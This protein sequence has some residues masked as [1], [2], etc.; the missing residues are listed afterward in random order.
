MSH[1]MKGRFSAPLRSRT[2]LS[3]S[4][5]LL[6]L[7]R[8][9][10]FPEARPGQFVSIRVSDGPSP[11]LRRPYSIMDLTPRSL[12]LLVKVVGRGSAMLADTRPGRTIDLIGPLGGSAFPEPAGAG[13]VLVA[14]GTGLAPLVFASR[15]WRRAR[16]G[17]ETHLLYGAS[18][19]GELLGALAERDFDERSFSTLDGTAGFRGDVVQLCERLLDEGRL[20]GRLLYSCGPRGMVRALAERA[21]GRFV[22]HYTSLECVMAC[23]LGA[24][25]GCTVPVT[26]P[27]GSAFKTVC[28]DGTVF[29][30]AEIAWEEWEG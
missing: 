4:C 10:G 14:G 16:L 22:E 23:G 21:G 28:S 20:A 17:V 27:G 6:V 5:S 24:C 1:E 19:K 25:R 15:A 11:L 30:A 29:R 3:P 9:E 13:A 26:A 2:E 7:E 18:T 8:P 12:S